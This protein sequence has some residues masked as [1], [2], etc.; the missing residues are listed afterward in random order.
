MGENG[1]GI[2]ERPWVGILIEPPKIE[3]VSIRFSAKGN[4]KN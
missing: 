1:D 4:E 2:K 3:I